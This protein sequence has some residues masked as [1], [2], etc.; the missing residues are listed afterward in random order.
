MSVSQHSKDDVRRAVSSLL[1]DGGFRASKRNRRFLEFVVEETLQGR[2]ERIKAYTIAVDVFG[3]S[4]NFDPSLDPI[5]RIEAARLR[6]SLRDYYE[7]FGVAADLQIVLP[8]GRYVPRFVPASE[9]K[10]AET[11]LASEFGDRTKVLVEVDAPAERLSDTLDAALELTID[12]LRLRDLRVFFK[13]SGN[14]ASG[15]DT[16]ERPFTGSGLIYA[17]S[18]TERAGAIRWRVS[19]LSTGEVLLTCKVKLFAD[20][21]QIVRDLNA[22]AQQIARMILYLRAR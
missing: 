13:P 19:E 16:F 21:E 18:L 22:V 6:A 5:V 20:A 10:C 1:T 15:S 8:L 9:K 11:F 4:P 3:R 14:G 7:G 2:G 17:V 12:N